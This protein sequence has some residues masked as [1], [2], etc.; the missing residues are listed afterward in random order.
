ME[1]APAAP[2]VPTPLAETLRAGAWRRPAD[3]AGFVG[4]VLAHLAGGAALLAALAG[5]YTAK[6]RLG[7]DVFPGVD[8]LP[9]PQIEATIDA[10]VRLLGW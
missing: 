1:A 5:A 6:R 8:V 9:D 10:V 7:I 4:P 2:P 3:L